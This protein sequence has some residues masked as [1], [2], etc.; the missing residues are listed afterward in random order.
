MVADIAAEFGRSRECVYL[1]CEKRL[2]IP[3]QKRQATKPWDAADIRY[4]L[5]YMGEKDPRRIANA[6]RRSYGSVVKKIRSLGGSSTVPRYSLRDLRR[7]L[8][9]SHT[10]L[11]RL[12]QQ[13]KLK[14]A[15]TRRPLRRGQ[16]QYILEEDLLDFLEKHLEEPELTRVDVTAKIRVLVDEALI[17]KDRPAANRH[18]ASA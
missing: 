3:R 12:I 2:G 14:V 11:A 10:R 6:L 4:L 13:G 18:A 16:Q 8:H 5:D 17:K 1:H 7:E 9:L 15:I